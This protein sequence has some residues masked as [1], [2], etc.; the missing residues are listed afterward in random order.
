MTFSAFERD[1]PLE[2]VEAFLANVRA[3]LTPMNPN[4]SD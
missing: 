2:L 1:L 4:A 3:A